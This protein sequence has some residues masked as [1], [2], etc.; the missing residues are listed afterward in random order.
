MINNEHKS[1]F[2]AFVLVVGVAA[3]ILVNGLREQAVGVLIEVRAPR[4]LISALA[5]D[6]VLGRTFD[7]ALSASADLAAPVDGPRVVADSPDASGSGPATTV[8]PIAAQAPRSTVQA[9]A[10]KT[11]PA[12]AKSKPAL[13]SP[14][15]VNAR[16]VTGSFV[17]PSA[18]P[19]KAKASSSL[20]VTSLR[21]PAGK[22][23]NTAHVKV[24]GKA[25]ARAKKS[26][27]AGHVKSLV[28]AKLPKG[29]H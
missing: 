11:L 2:V 21:S 9:V 14:R 19:A 3:L 4:P 29:K 10:P 13:S 24:H 15:P 22:V 6:M 5:P 1:V 28:A 27:K 23:H 26:A 12:P 18:K 20:R 7:R 17:K 8:G 16:P 25:A